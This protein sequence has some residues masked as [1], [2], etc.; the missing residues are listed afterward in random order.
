[1][2]VLDDLRGGLIVSV[3]AEAG[4]LL[5]TPETIALL[6]R[7]AQANGAVGVR[8]E[9]ARRIAAVRAAVRIPVIGIVKR[10]YDGFAPYITVTER[11]ID[12]A[13]GAGADII[14]FDATERSRPTGLDVAALC[15]A[16]AARGALPMADCASVPDGRIAAAAGAAIV[17]STLCGYT[18][19]TRGTPLPAL[20]LVRAL[21]ATGAFTICEGGVGAPGEVAAARAAGADAV[22]IGTAITNI[23]VLVRRFAAALKT[24]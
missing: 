18:E 3:Q 23:D 16:I 8:I 24:T 11:E 2:S 20:D 7:V 5:D 9:G 6:A 19:A 22:V 10:A 1:M 21:R 17:A 4:S 15:A 13:A 12:E 14:A